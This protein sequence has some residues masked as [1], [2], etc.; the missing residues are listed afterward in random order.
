V[1]MNYDRIRRGRTLPTR[2]Q[3]V[4]LAMRKA[5][6]RRRLSQTKLA[7]QSG[8]AL[9]SIQLVLKGH[10][11]KTSFWTIA[12]LAHALRLDLNYLAGLAPAQKGRPHGTYTVL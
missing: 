8:V 9:L 12:R 10:S 11:E 6:A 1:P 7:Q 5:C 4:A 3:L 2:P